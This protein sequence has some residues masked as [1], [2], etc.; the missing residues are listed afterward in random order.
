MLLGRSDVRADTLDNRNQTPLSLASSKG[1]GGVVK[2]I[3]ERS[4]VN[5]DA[6]DHSGQASLP[7]STGHE[8]RCAV[9][10]HSRADDPNTIITN[11]TAQSELP[12]A[13]H[14]ER[15][16]LSDLKDSASAP[17]DSD[18]PLPKSPRP[19]RPPSS[20]PLKFWYPLRKTGPRPTTQS[21]FSPTVDRRFIIPAFICLFAFLLYILPSSFLDVFSFRK[22]SPSEGSA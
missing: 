5:S 15:P 21:T 19:P 17:A 16:K 2:A 22:Y 12:S 18:S 7:A 10:I 4:N 11:L 14:D 8:G 3:L 1:H 20:W 9:K 6:V 13:D